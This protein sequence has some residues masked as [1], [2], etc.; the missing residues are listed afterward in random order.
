MKVYFSWSLML[1]VK[2]LCHWWHTKSFIAPS[3]FFLLDQNPS[4]CGHKLY[5]YY[6]NIGQNY[7]KIH[8]SEKTACLGLK[9]DIYPK[10]KVVPKTLSNCERNEYFFFQKKYFGGVLAVLDWGIFGTFCYFWGPTNPTK[11]WIYYNLFYSWT[12]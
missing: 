2:L 5:L 12:K 11:T 3:L 4:F 1:F 10:T 7:L 6:M 9:N 8:V